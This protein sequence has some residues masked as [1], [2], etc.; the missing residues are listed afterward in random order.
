MKN[1]ITRCY[2]C[3][4][5]IIKIEDV[6]LCD[7]GSSL[8]NLCDKEMCKKCAN[9]VGEDTHVCDEHNHEVAIR[10]AKKLRKRLKKLE[11]DEGLNNSPIFICKRDN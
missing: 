3:G 7:Y 4:K 10:K 2:K 8:L 5:R 1:K 11:K 6:K 9:L